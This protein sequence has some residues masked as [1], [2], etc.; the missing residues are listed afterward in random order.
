METHRNID[1]EKIDP[2][3]KILLTGLP[4]AMAVLLG[5]WLTSSN[6][7]L[8][9]SLILLIVIFFVISFL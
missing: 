8:L 3:L 9:F 6:V 1:K 2:Y 7:I 5:Q 4:T